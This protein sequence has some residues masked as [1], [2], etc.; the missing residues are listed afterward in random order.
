MTTTSHT[1]HALLSI[2]SKRINSK[3]RIREYFHQKSLVSDEILREQM[4][5]QEAMLEIYR[6]WHNKI[7]VGHDLKEKLDSIQVRID[8]VLGIKD[9]QGSKAVVERTTTTDRNWAEVKRLESIYYQIL[10]KTLRKGRIHDDVKA[11][12]EIYDELQKNWSDHYSP[13]I[14]KEKIKLPKK[15]RNEDVLK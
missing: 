12:K 10:R 8:E 15:D 1:L 6:Y 5:E 13:T 7:I 4:D 14:V 11:I 3:K 2:Y 9:I